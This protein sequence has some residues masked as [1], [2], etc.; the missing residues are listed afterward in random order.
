MAKLIGSLLPFSY[1]TSNLR[2]LETMEESSIKFSSQEILLLLTTGFS[3][4]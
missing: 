1:Y 4:C 2:E 3:V